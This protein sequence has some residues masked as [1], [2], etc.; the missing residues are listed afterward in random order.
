VRK[1]A[2]GPLQNVLAVALGAVFLYA[3]FDKIAH[4]G[5]FAR[6][7]YHYRLIGPSQ[8]VGPWAANLLAVTLPWIEVMVGLSLVTGVW[9]R[10]GAAL[11]AALLLVFVGA[12]AAALWR[13]IDIENCGCFSVTGA[14][15]A[16]GLKLV[17]GDAALVL[18]ALLLAFEPARPADARLA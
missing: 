14:G 10:E 17:L 3:S 2:A 1:G 9:R 11:A 8:E 13:G 12:V 6:I 16:A 4:P 18:V 15:R 5:E 7:V